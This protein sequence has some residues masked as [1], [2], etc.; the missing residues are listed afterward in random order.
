VRDSEDYGFAAGVVNREIDMA[1]TLDRK[2]I[3][4][5]IVERATWDRDFREALTKDPHK[6]LGSFFKVDVPASVEIKTLVETEKSFYIVL[7]YMPDEA[8]KDKELSTEE[9]AAV[10]GGGWSSSWASCGFWC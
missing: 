5:K 6:A 10:A 9:L 7:P 8:A 3:E 1:E 2:E 4:Q